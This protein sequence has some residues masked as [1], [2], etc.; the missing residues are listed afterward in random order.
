MSYVFLFIL[1]FVIPL[2]TQ[3]KIVRADRENTR[4]LLLSEH[5]Q[6]GHK[7]SDSP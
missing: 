2:Y 1:L 5:E 3:Q 6:S 7:K 4:I